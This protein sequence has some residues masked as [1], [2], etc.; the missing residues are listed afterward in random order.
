MSLSLLAPLLSLILIQ[1]A[2]ISSLVSAFTLQNVTLA[3]TDPSIKYY[4]TC[5][6]GSEQACAGAWFEDS[7]NPDYYNGTAVVAGN[8]S[9]TYANQEPYMTYSFTG[10]AIYVYQ[11]LSTN[12]AVQGDFFNSNTH[13]GTNF[14]ADPSKYTSIPITSTPQL[15]LS[16]SLTD[17]DPTR[18]HVIS[19]QHQ[20]D[21]SGRE[22]F[23]TLDHIVVTQ[24]IGSVPKSSGL[25]G[26]AKTAITIVGL[27]VGITSFFGLICLRSRIRSKRREA[28]ADKKMKI[29]MGVDTNSTT[30]GSSFQLK[31]MDA[32]DDKSTN[33]PPKEEPKQKETV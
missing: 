25:S 3:A 16:W 8:P 33:E 24:T 15:I 5:N 26:S 31:W 17:L 29:L 14:T 1:S 6:G 28:E 32:G 20:S 22:T 11:W 23:V 21:A 2:S 18:Q 7:S 10:S 4:P 12:T 9:G 13:I 30:G 27:V 19:I